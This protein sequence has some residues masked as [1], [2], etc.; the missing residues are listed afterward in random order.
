MFAFNGKCMLIII[1]ACFTVLALSIAANAEEILFEDD[2]G[3][4]SLAEHWHVTTGDNSLTWYNPTHLAEYRVQDGKLVVDAPA[5]DTYFDIQGYK[6][7]GNISI[8][9][10]FKI[11]SKKS[12]G[13]GNFCLYFHRPED[14]KSWW[15]SRG[16]VVGFRRDE[17][18]SVAALQNI[19]EYEIWDLLW[20]KGLYDE[21]HVLKVTTDS[22]VLYMNLDGEDVL[23]DVGMNIPRFPF[24]GFSVMVYDSIVSFDYVKIY[25]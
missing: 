25:R 10:K 18:I 23:G 1:C 14:Y 11:S 6:F 4:D 7:T 12:H 3:G 24:G 17:V 21:W 16:I 20:T 2:F 15:D 22:T 19:A 5:G 8:E 9:V 13:V